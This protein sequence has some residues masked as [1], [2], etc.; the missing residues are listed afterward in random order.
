MFDNP[1]ST[2]FAEFELIA[3]L[4]E[5]HDWIFAKT[6]PDNPHEYTLRKRWADQAAFDRVVNGIRRLGYKTLFRRRPY[7]QL[8]VNEHYYWTMGAP[9]PATILINRKRRSPSSHPAPYDV[10]APGYD[11]LFSSQVFAEENRELFARLGSLAAAS[12][13]DVG[14]GTGLLLDHARPR[15]YL[16]ID[17]SLAMLKR[18]HDKHPA[19]DQVRTRYTTLGAFAGDRYDQVTALFG[20]ASYL[21]DA[22]LARIP[23]LLRPEGRAFLMFYAPGYAPITHDALKVT[24]PAIRHAPPAAPASRFGHYD[25][26]EIPAA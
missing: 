17:P 20:A 3:K 9:V 13:L 2:D 25:L 26:V 7:T 16:G 8:N 19:S 15:Q 22:D 11:A 1:P 5:A 24:V 14:C 12:V 10:A 23:T 6:M 21:T 4:L 18:L